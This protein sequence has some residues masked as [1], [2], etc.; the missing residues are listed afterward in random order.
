M[1]YGVP[2]KDMKQ[3]EVPQKYVNKAH[4]NLDAV[5]LVHARKFKSS[6]VQPDLLAGRR[7]EFLDFDRVYRII[8]RKKRQAKDTGV[9]NSNKS[10]RYVMD[11]KNFI[12]TTQ[13]RRKYKNL[14]KSRRTKRQINID[15]L[16]ASSLAALTQYLRD[17]LLNGTGTIQMRYGRSV[18]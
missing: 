9:R 10:S 14:L 3:I 12:E 13:N 4:M 16:D 1:V 6:E 7:S 18:K 15:Q 11:I 5:E 17:K 8:M 2:V